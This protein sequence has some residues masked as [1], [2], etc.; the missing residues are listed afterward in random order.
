[1]KRFVLGVLAIC[2]SITGLFFASNNQVQATNNDNI[3]I[4]HATNSNENPYTNPTVDKSS[5][6]TVPNGHDTHNGGIYPTNNWGDIIPPFSYEECPSN[7]SAYGSWWWGKTCEKRISGHTRYAYPITVNYAGKNWTT[8]GQAIYNNQ[9]NV[10]VA[11]PTPTPSPTATP[12]P[13][14]TPSPTATPKPT[15]TATPIP[16]ENKLEITNICSTKTKNVYSVTNTNDHDKYFNVEV[17]GVTVSTNNLVPA[18]STIEIT[19]TPY[20]VTEFIYKLN[21]E[22]EI[23]EVV[24]DSGKMCVEPT[25][26]PK[27]TPPPT[28]DPCN[29]ETR[30]LVVQEEGC[31]EELIIEFVCTSEAKHTFSVTNPNA[32]DVDF[33]VTIDGGELEPG[34]TVPANSSILFSVPSDTNGVVE[35]HYKLNGKT[36]IQTVSAG[37]RLCDEPEP[38]PTPSPTPEPEDDDE[39]DVHNKLWV[40]FNCSANKWETGL[41]LKKDDNPI[42][43]AKIDYQYYNQQTTKYS[44]KDGH[45]NLS[46]DDQGKGVLK[47]YIDSFDGHE[48]TLNKPACEA[49]EPQTTTGRV[50]GASTEPQ[51]AN[52]GSAA[53]FQA[54]IAFAVSLIAG[55][56]TMLIERKLR[57]A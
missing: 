44:D 51:Y 53:E 6:I 29:T 48:V 50:L 3:R 26:T 22:E 23:H 7:N 5:I 42:F 14:P 8:Q 19:V 28:P 35:F 32:T 2:L 25:P 39:K 40:N 47:V 17:D 31:Q 30:G 57:N 36:H 20:G 34:D 33:L 37:E 15:P 11:T 45:S 9:C 46:F 52:T 49:Q 27:P 18:N 21:S 16:V 10:P 13:T 1:M 38:T 12:T 41:S 54:Q 56:A 24:A 55:F 43:N 4:C